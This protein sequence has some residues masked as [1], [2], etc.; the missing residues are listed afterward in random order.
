MADNGSQPVTRA[1]LREELAAF[2]ARLTK[3]LTESMRDMQTE[4]LRAFHGWAGPFEQRMRGT[5]SF[6]MGFEERLALLEERVRKIESDRL[7]K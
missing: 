2:E 3:S 6:V 5:Q 1:E 4:T 7:S